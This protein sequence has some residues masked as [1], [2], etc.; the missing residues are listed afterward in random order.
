M[1][2]IPFIENAFK[3]GVSYQDSS[4]INIRLTCHDQAL[5]FIVVNHI[6]KSHGDEIESGS[7]I[8]LKNVTRRLELLYP[9]MHQLRISDKG[10]QYNVELNIRF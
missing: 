10:N 2:L 8:G 3:H 9:G 6:A 1:L 7:G 4:E 5:S